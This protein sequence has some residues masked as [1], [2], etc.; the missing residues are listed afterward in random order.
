MDCYG[1]KRTKGRSRHVVWTA[2]NPPGRACEGRH[3]SDSAQAG[4]IDGIVSRTYAVS[5]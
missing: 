4:V 1:G 3:Q 2:G 5:V